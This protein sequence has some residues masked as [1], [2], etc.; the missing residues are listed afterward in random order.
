M[1]VAHEGSHVEDAE[2]WAD[3]GFTDA[4]R[5]TNLETEFRAYRIDADFADVFGYNMLTGSLG[6]ES[7]LF[8]NRYFPQGMNDALTTNMVKNFYPNWSL[9]AWQSN[10]SGGAH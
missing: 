7:H 1:T 9:K 8:W 5:P 2:D 3:A 10:T 6:G 4:A